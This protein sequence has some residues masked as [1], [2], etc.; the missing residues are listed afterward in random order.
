MVKFGYEEIKKHL[1]SFLAVLLAFGSVGYF[2]YQQMREVEKDRLAVE[3]SRLRVD[4]LIRETDK[5]VDLLLAREKSIVER[6]NRVEQKFKELSINKELLELSLKFINETKDIDIRKTCWD[7]DKHNI[8]AKNAKSLL[9][10]I[11]AKAKEHR[12]KDYLDFVDGQL[13]RK[14][15]QFMSGG[16]CKS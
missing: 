6:E 14:G 16:N 8:R 9:E 15:M 2:L 11:G 3:E 10:L 12:R 7:D 5:K 1:G 4:S 13:Q